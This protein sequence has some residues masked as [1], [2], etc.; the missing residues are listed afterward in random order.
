MIIRKRPIISW[1]LDTSKIYE[2]MKFGVPLIDN[3][4]H[5]DYLWSGIDHLMDVSRTYKPN[6]GIPEIIMSSLVRLWRRVLSRLL[7]FTIAF[8]KNFVMKKH[9]VY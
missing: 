2:T 7:K 5:H 4:E 9:V 6:W 1:L 3:K 8:F